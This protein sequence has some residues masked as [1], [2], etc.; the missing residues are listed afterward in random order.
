MQADIRDTATYNEAE[1]LYRRLLQPGSGQ[2]SDASELNY[3][4][5]GE[6]V[7]F[8][9]AIAQ[10]LDGAVPTRI[11]RMQLASGDIQVLT[12]GPN[13]DRSPK[14]SAD[15][16]SI[17]FLSDRHKRGDFQLYLLDAASGAIHAAPTVEGWVEYLHWSP[18]GTRILLGVAG[19]GADLAG[20]QG[21]VTTA[22]SETSGPSWLPSVEAGE[23]DYRWR[24]VWVVD[25]VTHRA[26]QITQP[27]CNV[28]EAVWCGE[29][30]I[31]AITSPGPQEGDWYSAHLQLIDVATGQGREIYVPQDQLAWLAASASG[32]C[33]AVVEAFCSDRGLAAG[34]LRLIDTTAGTVRPI[35]T[36]GVDV[37]CIEWR[38][39]RHLLL[40]GHRGFS[41]VIGV[42]DLDQ[43][44]FVEHWHSDR[45]STSEYIKV[46]GLD[47]TG[48][49]LFVA[50]SFLDAPQIAMV[51]AG[52]Y[53]TLKS[54]D[55][56]FADLSQ[57]IGSVEQVR[58]PA[59][60]GME[61]QGWLLS[62]PGTGPHPVILNCHG[63][64]VAHWRSFWLGR[65][66]WPFLLML[67]KRGYAL[68]FA[69]PRGSSGR[70]QAFVRPI[71]GDLGGIDGRDLL[72]GLDALVERGIAPAQPVGVIG[73]SYGGF[74]TSWLITQDPRFSAAVAVAPITNHVTERLTSNIPH[75]V[76]L[77]L[78]ES[79]HEAIETYLRHSPV[80][81]AHKA[82]TPTLN[83]CGALDRCTPPSEA[84]QFHNAL[85]ENGVISALLTYPEE[86]HGI[87]KFPAAIDFVARVVGWFETHMPIRA[88]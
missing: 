2:I 71:V 14:Y 40:A 33:L 27:G 87:R 81:F 19:H 50:E 82:R 30:Q 15:G 39:E 26:Q 86:G 83:I 67:V 52:E 37:T 47:A 31:A 51:R 22:Q 6:R 69:N 8:S 73:G 79:Y 38:S 63:G 60:D 88:G 68:F 5:A 70:G 66:R 10:T 45:V 54:F 24:S 59:S 4:P 65:G 29:S 53:R 16:G 49:C 75:F 17:A 44:T 34:N 64:P 13:T 77:F 76:K 48:A 12:T 41:V 20:R 57:Q 62:P 3:G 32:Q 21:A 18:Q 55:L 78:G 42:Y 74:I 25:P 84:R 56:G 1:A 80:M 58:W 35:D 36:H 11:C 61:I 72:A 85:L 9:G 23:E 28:W 7:I 43:D 46:C